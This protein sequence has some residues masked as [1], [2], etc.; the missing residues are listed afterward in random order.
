[1]EQLKQRD[2]SPKTV[3]GDQNF[4]FGK[5]KVLSKEKQREKR[6]FCPKKESEQTVENGGSHHCVTIV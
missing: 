4:R 2:K 5:T 6:K 3:L 1:M